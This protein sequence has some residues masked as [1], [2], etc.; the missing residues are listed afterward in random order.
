V[1]ALPVP[2]PESERDFR[3]TKSK[4]V[5]APGKRTKSTYATKKT[6]VI[7]QRSRSR[8]V[9]SIDLSLAPILIHVTETGFSC[10][11]N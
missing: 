3:I 9:S 5:H 1:V 6:L 10:Y 2:L 11:L 7:F 8:V 4:W